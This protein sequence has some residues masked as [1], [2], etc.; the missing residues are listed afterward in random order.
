MG[1]FYRYATQSIKNNSDANYFLYEIIKR[2]PKVKYILTNKVMSPMII[3]INEQFS[4]FFF[5][6][7][8]L[9]QKLSIFGI[10]ELLGKGML[11][12]AGQNWKDQRQILANEFTFGKIL[13]R[14]DIIN[15][16]VQGR[17]KDIDKKPLMTVLSSITGEVVFQAFFGL[18]S[19]ENMINNKEPQIEI[20]SILDRIGINFRTN[21]LLY[22]KYRFFGKMFSKY[23]MTQTELD[24]NHRIEYFTKF[25]KNLIRQRKNQ[26]PDQTYFIDTVLSQEKLNDD[27]IIQLF[28]TLIFA[29]TETTA[30]A[31]KTCLYYLAL[32]QDIQEQLHQEIDKIV[33]NQ[34][35]QV[36]QIKELNLIQNFI[37]EVLRLRNPVLAPIQRRMVPD[38]QIGDI[39]I[40]KGTWVQAATYLNQIHQKNY[41][42]PF[43]F[44][45]NREKPINDNGFINIPFAS[46]QRNCIG[47]HMALL[48]LKIILVNIL[49]QYKLKLKE[50]VQIVWRMSLTYSIQQNDFIEFIKRN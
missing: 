38:I 26:K 23:F 30:T 16:V 39:F 50:S 32:H 43:C 8:Q 7:H 19:R 45:I 9:F 2:N 22:L 47:Q 3:V 36:S 12:A 28:N 41:E 37:S 1:G 6:E 25:I 21:R 33:G 15:D 17:I 44:D 46:G 27:E 29:G 49:Q 48:E 24:I 31:A 35:L 13:E 4:K 10:D 34:R 20:L 42:N 18:N 14:T 40:K 5:Q 11:F